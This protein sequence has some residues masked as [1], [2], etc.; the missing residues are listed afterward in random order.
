M[1]SSAAHGVLVTAGG[2]AVLS[3]GTTVTGCR[4]RGVAAMGGA[5]VTIDGGAIRGCGEGG[6]YAVGRQPSPPPPV[7]QT[8]LRARALIIEECQLRSVVATAGAVLSLDSSCRVHGGRG[9]GCGDY[10]VFDGGVI[11][12]VA[13]ELIA[14]FVGHHEAAGKGGLPSPL[15]VLAATRMCS[16]TSRLVRRHAVLPFIVCATAAAP[17]PP[18]SPTWVRS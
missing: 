17:P 16:P 6:L 18:P 10:A 9:G 14:G 2:R 1:H 11:E 7:P 13:P 12:G 15:A 8:Q 5:Q 4:W 3:G